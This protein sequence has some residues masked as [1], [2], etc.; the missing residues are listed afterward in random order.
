MSIGEKFKHHLSTAPSLTSLSFFQFYHWNWRRIDSVV[1][2]FQSIHHVN[3]ILEHIRWFGSLVV[4]KKTSNFG[5]F[6]VSS[7]REHLLKAEFEGLDFELWFSTMILR[8]N[9]CDYKKACIMIIYSTVNFIS[10]MANCSMRRGIKW[11]IIKSF[12]SNPFLVLESYLAGYSV[13]LLREWPISIRMRGRV[14]RLSPVK[15]HAANLPKNKSWPRRKF[16]PKKSCIKE[17]SLVEK[18]SFIMTA[19]RP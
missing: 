12:L 17:F 7:K 16:A 5:Q 14:D 1:S 6:A 4:R 13:L 11:R 8:W 18:K 3:Q 10:L 2:K 19:F 9:A 15:N